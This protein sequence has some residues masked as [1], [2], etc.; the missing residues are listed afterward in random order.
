MAEICPLDRIDLGSFAGGLVVGPER[1]ADLLAESYTA[2]LEQSNE[3]F[4]SLF[5]GQL[6]DGM[7]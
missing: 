6:A 1:E 7:L 4:N 2:A 5:G 3:L